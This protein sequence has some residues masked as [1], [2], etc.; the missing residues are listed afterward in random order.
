[1]KNKE[2]DWNKIV[3]LYKAET[4]KR[5]RA[6]DLIPIYY[7]SAEFYRIKTRSTYRVYFDEARNF[8]SSWI[9]VTV[10]DINTDIV[11]RVFDGSFSEFG[12]WVIPWK[13]DYEIFN[14]KERCDWN[15]SKE[16][17]QLFKEFLLKYDT[18]S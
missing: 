16:I 17:V 8:D 5:Y 9:T 4:K 13:N 14:H 18:S 10:S 15:N 2:K 7:S 6:G 12:G 11:A 3:K 1:M